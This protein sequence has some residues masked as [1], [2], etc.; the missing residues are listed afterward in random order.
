MKTKDNRTC[1]DSRKKCQKF[2]NYDK[3]EIEVKKETVDNR[4]YHVNS[5][6]IK[7]F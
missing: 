5:D 2:F 4:S 1:R 3:I 7:K 6:K